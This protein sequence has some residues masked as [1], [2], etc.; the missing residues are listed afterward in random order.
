[1][2]KKNANKIAARARQEAQGGHY[3]HHLR[4]KGGAGGTSDRTAQVLVFDRSGQRHLGIVWFLPP[5]LGNR[6]A[7]PTE[8]VIIG[9]IPDAIEGQ[10]LIVEATGRVRH[11]MEKRNAGD[12][13]FLVRFSEPDSFATLHVIYASPNVGP[14]GMPT[15]YERYKVIPDRK[16]PPAGVFSLGI[17][18]LTEGATVKGVCVFGQP[19]WGELFALLDAAHPGIERRVAIEGAEGSVDARDRADANAARRGDQRYMTVYCDHET[20]MRAGAGGT[21]QV[22]EL[23]E[24]ERGTDVTYLVDQGLMFHELD[25]LRRYLVEKTGDD[26]ELEEGS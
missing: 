16:Q 26:I 14:Y 23:Q 8:G 4:H 12:G 22:I 24:G 18:P 17:L 13:A 5:G 10:S 3:Q 25:E 6:P 19:A 21:F 2:T 15:T 9:R 7:S 20:P 11:I 1:M